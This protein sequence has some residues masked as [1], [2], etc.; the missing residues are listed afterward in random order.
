MF[1]DWG[2]RLLPFGTRVARYWL[3][4]E[5][6]GGL[7]GIKS[8]FVLASIPLASKLYFLGPQLGRAKPTQCPPEIYDNDKG[9]VAHADVAEL[10]HPHPHNSQT[11]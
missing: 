11:L 9:Q 1:W 5:P 10:D 3:S 8:I 7:V 6:F 2:D 4:L